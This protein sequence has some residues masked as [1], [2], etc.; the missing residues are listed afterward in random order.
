[1]EIH[2]LEFEDKCLEKVDKGE[3]F[4]LKRALDGLKIS[5]REEQSENI[6][7]TRHTING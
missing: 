7:H 4:V 3:L 2:L 6:F 1:M 5:N